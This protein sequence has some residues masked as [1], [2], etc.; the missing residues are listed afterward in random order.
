ML[1]E[2]EVSALAMVVLVE[3]ALQEEVAMVAMEEARLLMQEV[4]LV[5]PELPVSELPVLPVGRVA[6]DI[7][8]ASP[9]VTQ[10]EVEVKEVKTDRK[11]VVVET[12]VF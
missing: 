4:L 3:G 11:V 5:L 10:E 1:E 7:M 8:T 2:T 9:E 6:A 12:V